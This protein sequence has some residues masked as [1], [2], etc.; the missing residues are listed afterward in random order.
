MTSEAYFLAGH[1]CNF[2]ERR[3]AG[4]Y[5]GLLPLVKAV[6]EG[7]VLVTGAQCGKLSQFETICSDIYKYEIQTVFD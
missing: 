5:S 6:P 1:G 7:V 4:A 3:F 2:V